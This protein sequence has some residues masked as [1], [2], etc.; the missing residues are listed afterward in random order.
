MLVVAAAILFFLSIIEA[1]FVMESVE[2]TPLNSYRAT[3]AIERRVYEW[4]WREFSIRAPEELPA[5]CDLLVWKDAHVEHNAM[6]EPEVIGRKLHKCKQCAKSFKSW[7]YLDL[8]IEERH[9]PNRTTEAC[10]ARYCAFI[11]CGSTEMNSLE[12]DTAPTLISTLH[13]HH[14]ERTRTAHLCREVMAK[15][16]PPMKSTKFKLAHEAMETRFCEGRNRKKSA[17][18]SLSSKAPGFSLSVIFSWIVVAGIVGFY[19]YH[20]VTNRP[21]KLANRGLGYTKRAISPPLAAPSLNSTPPL[22]KP[23]RLVGSTS[24]TNSSNDP[25]Q[26]LTQGQPSNV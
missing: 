25:L 9:L 21:Q 24:T 8:H 19:V 14:P 1:K 3:K 12:L 26:S 16:F 17:Q 10:L 6:R 18:F 23:R 11:P 13:E 22:T 20:F 7:E 15:C 4:A 2:C 5:D